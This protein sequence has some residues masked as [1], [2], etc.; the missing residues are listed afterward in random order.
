MNQKGTL[1]M[2]SEDKLTSPRTAATASM[3]LGAAGAPAP[4]PRSASDVRWMD[5]IGEVDAAVLSGDASAM[6]RSWQ[7]ASVAALLD[8]EW[9]SMVAV[10]DAAIRIGR[11]TGLR[12]A[13][14]AK[15]RQAYHVALFRSHRASSLD[16]V[17]CAAE[18]FA[19]LGDADVVEQCLTIAQRL[20]NPEAPAAA[21]E[22]MT[23]LRTRLTG[24]R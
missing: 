9:P 7:A 20:G 12:V 18:G 10:G 2:T 17:L 24:S 5:L 1:T 23:L 16:G 21:Q 3:M 14:G 13:F 19:E 15:A 22:K 11:A 6:L 4:A 8:K